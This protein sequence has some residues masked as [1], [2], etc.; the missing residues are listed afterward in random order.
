[1]AQRE[2]IMRVLFRVSVLLFTIN[3]VR[4]NESWA[5]SATAVGAGGTILRTD[6]GGDTWTPQ[7][8]GT[9]NPL[10]GV[11]LVDDC[12]GTVVGAAGTIRSEEHTSELQ[13]QFHLVC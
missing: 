11:S 3:N 8:S 2:G 13:S 5:Q 9:H 10:S 6:D 4:T 12:T 1:M 7:D